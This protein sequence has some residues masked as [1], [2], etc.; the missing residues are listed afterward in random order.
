MHPGRST[1]LSYAYFRQVLSAVKHSFTAHVLGNAPDVLPKSTS[2]ALFL[3]HDIRVSLKRA[4]QMAEIE[5]EYG[6][7]A[8]YM[9]QAD[10]PLYSL[11]ERQTRIHLLELLQL[12]HEVGLH[13][14][15]SSTAHQQQ[16]FRAIVENQLR[17]LCTCIEQITCRPVRAFSLYRPVPQLYNGPLLVAGRVNADA[18]KLRQWLLMDV[19]GTWHHSDLLTGMAQHGGPVLQ[20]LLYPLWWG[21]QHLPTSVRLQEFFETA[22]HNA[23]ARE[24][25]LFDINLTKAVPAIRRQGLYDLVREEVLV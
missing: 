14:D 12:G 7:P 6:L 17:P 19:G 2:P 10:S 11:N 24:A 16:S 21:H 23:S 18:R 25:A 3:R 8:T 15:L 5:Y 4:V 9:V 20:L 22:T 1:H 13:F